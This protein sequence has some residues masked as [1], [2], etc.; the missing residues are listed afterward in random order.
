MGPSDAL[1]AVKL[2]H[3]RHVIP[4]HFDTFD[5]IRQDAAAWAQE[6]QSQTDTIVHLLQPGETFI[7]D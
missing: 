2:L 4:I 1:R 3:P 5:L 7:S 6:V